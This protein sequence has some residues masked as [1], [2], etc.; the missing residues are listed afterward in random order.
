MNMS[1]GKLRL[2]IVATASIA[3]APSAFGVVFNLGTGINGDLPD[4][5]A[6]YAT[7]T[8]VNAGVDAVT[9]TMDN[10]APIENFIVRVALNLSSNIDVAFAYV[11]GNVADLTTDG[12]NHSTGHP[13]MQAGLFDV[14][15]GYP[16]SGSDPNRFNGGE[17]SVYTLT[18]TGLDET[19][20]LSLSTE[21]WM[22]A[23]RFQGISNDG[24]GTV[25]HLPEPATMAALGLGAV[26]ML[27]RRRK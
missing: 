27:R 13:S 8:I 9:V 17:D 16:T 11:S 1:L 20:F 18:G 4:G 5:S 12:P 22:A 7:I 19:D 14:V 26:A 23:A 15:F 3:V 25:G 10:N 2:A 24:S 21:G 6:P